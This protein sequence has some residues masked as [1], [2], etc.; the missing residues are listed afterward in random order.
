[1]KFLKRKGFSLIEIVIVMFLTGAVLGLVSSLVTR[2]FETLRF[3]QEKG[4][5]MQSAT[6]GGERL[7][8]EMR[9]MVELNSGGTGG[10]TIRF[11]KVN[12]SAPEGV[13]N[14]PLDLTVLASTWARD[15]NTL[16]E[17]ARITYS[18]AAGPD[19]LE[20]EVRYRGSTQTSVVATAVN[21]FTIDRYNGIGNCFQVDLSILER[22]RVVIFV[23]IVNCP[24]LAP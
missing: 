8:A 21:A 19:H 1:M 23:Y 16:N 22:R 13:N 14:D 20:R 2:T 3:L 24:G 17:R 5:T 6:L 18:L 15:Y 7:C 9:E 11:F 12:P 4:Q 10:S